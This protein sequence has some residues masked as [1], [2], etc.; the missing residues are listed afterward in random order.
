[1]GPAPELK[2]EALRSSA[3]SANSSAVASASESPSAQP[4]QLNPPPLAAEQ[5]EF[6][7][8]GVLASVPTCRNQV[9]EF[10]SAHCPD[11]GDQ[12]DILLALQEA[13]A[14]AALHGCNDDPS[15]RIRCVVT[16]GESDVTIVVR[17]SG[18]G[19]DLKLADPEKFQATAL[20]H[21][22]GICLMRSL[23]TDISFAHNG[24]EIQMRKLINRG[25]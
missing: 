11:E 23:M 20:T 25:S 18:P 17:D 12:I 9:M 15:Q 4:S 16:A 7:F 13:L 8:P 19:F 24:A 5:Q 1:M 6:E 14:N 10:V 21:G 2:D 22:R 3:T